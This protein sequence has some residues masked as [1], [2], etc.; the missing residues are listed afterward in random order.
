MGPADRE[1][2]GASAAPPGPRAVEARGRA[3]GKPLGNDD[4]RPARS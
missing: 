1:R 2:P 4:L 3:G